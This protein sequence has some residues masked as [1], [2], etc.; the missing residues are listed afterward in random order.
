MPA[1]IQIPETDCG[2][3]CSV[4]LVDVCVCVKEAFHIITSSKGLN[5]PNLLGCASSL[6]FRERQ[7]ENACADGGF[8]KETELWFCFVVS[9]SGELLTSCLGS[10]KHNF[11]YSEPFGMI[12]CIKTIGTSRGIYSGYHSFLVP[13]V[14]LSLMFHC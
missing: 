1:E 10:M 14:L 6:F 7:T 13:Y 11:E 5:H 8:F 9:S 12:Y 3:A 4:Q 2:L